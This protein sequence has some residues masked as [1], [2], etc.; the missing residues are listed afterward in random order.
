MHLC[1]FATYMHNLW[2]WDE[3]N[4]DQNCRLGVTWQ[5]GRLYRYDCYRYLGGI[6]SPI[7]AR[8]DS[9][10]WFH[11]AWPILTRRCSSDNCGRRRCYLSADVVKGDL[12]VTDTIN[13]TSHVNA[14][15]LVV[16]L[17]RVNRARGDV[18]P[19]LRLHQQHRDVVSVGCVSLLNLS[20]SPAYHST[21][22]SELQ[23]EPITCSSLTK[24]AGEIK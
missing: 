24:L 12:W 23:S 16:N 22:M 13:Q 5:W 9:W 14:L 20:Q 18:T 10:I 1:T 19:R 17:S 15:P 11:L 21:F 8:W 2:H 4:S 6:M 3:F 7:L